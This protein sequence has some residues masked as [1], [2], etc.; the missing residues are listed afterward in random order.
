MEKIR[1]IEGSLKTLEMGWYALIPFIGVFFAVISV[2][3][4]ARTITFAEGQWNPAKAHL[5]GGMA[6]ALLSLLGHGLLLAIA[7]WGLMVMLI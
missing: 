3:V 5:F 2:V 6:L 7:A 1:L 4:F